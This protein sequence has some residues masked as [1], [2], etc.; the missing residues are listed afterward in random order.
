[1]PA[2]DDPLVETALRRRRT[3]LWIQMFALPVVAALSCIALFVAWQRQGDFEEHAVSV[4]AAVTS[5]ID[6]EGSG[7][8]RLAEVTLQ[9]DAPDGEA[10]QVTKVM[11][12]PPARGETLA[13]RYDKRKP[14]HVYVGVEGSPEHVLAAGVL[15]A[16]FSLFALIVSS[17][18]IERWRGVR[19]VRKLLANTEWKPALIEQW[20]IG[21]QQ[22]HVTLVS[23]VQEFPVRQ[24]QRDR[25]IGQSLLVA[26][27]SATT[28]EMA[29]G[30]AGDLVLRVP[31]VSRL[32]YLKP[33]RTK[34]RPLLRRRLDRLARESPLAKSWENAAG[35]IY[36]EAELRAERA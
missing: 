34:G 26:L 16:L 35:A 29:C 10:H 11:A 25:S 3:A 27:E 22:K 17:F 2:I 24:F 9:W 12:G 6:R 28:Y 30:S 33:L 18:G 36:S 7:D 8:L 4:Q 5:V 14:D 21:I 15:S 13:I 31:G 23:G 20:V 1:M 19:K 32:S